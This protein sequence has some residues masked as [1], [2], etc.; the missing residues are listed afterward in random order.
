MNPMN[1]TFSLTTQ[2]DPTRLPEADLPAQGLVLTRPD[3]AE[4]PFAAF[5][6]LLEEITLAGD[7]LLW[8]LFGG[9]FAGRT[10]EV[11]ITATCGV[12]AP[13]D[14]WCS[15]GGRLYFNLSQWSGEALEKFGRAVI[16]HETAH[17][18]IRQLHPVRTEAGWREKLDY[19]VFD[20]GVAHYVGFPLGRENLLTKYA[21]KWPRAEARLAE[22]YR[23]LDDPHTREAEKSALLEEADTGTYWE[24]FGSIS[25]MFRA[26][27]L[28]AED[29]PALIGCIR[30]GRL[31]QRD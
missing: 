14:A 18:L 12:P 5:A 22:A 4:L 21:E 17:F 9:F 2:P 23:L 28:D 26:A 31:P 30:E 16:L 20:E 19:L 11:P 8:D 25:G 15:S 3:A 27:R 1:L 24:K 29:R 13:Y 10:F 7:P 6:R